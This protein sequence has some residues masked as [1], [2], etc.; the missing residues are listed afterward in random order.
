[1]YLA[2]IFNANFT[3]RCLRV[4]AP[5]PEVKT[6]FTSVTGILGYRPSANFKYLI[7]Q[8]Y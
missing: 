3:V 4:S 1:M 2:W 6:V 8:A 7:S 5:D